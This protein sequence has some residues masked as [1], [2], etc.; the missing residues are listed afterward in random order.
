[1]KS[2]YSLL[3]MLALTSVAMAGTKIATLNVTPGAITYPDQLVGSTSAVATVN[4]KNTSTAKIAFSS[5]EAYGDFH[6]LENGCDKLNPNGKCSVAVT[7]TP[8]LAGSRTGTLVLI[9]NAVS[10]PQ[11][12]ALFGRG[13][14]PN[15]PSPP[16]P[17]PVNASPIVT[18]GANQS[19]TLPATATLSAT[20][21]DDGLPVTSRLSEGW[22]VV[23][24]PGTVSFSNS[25]STATSASFSSPGVYTLRLTA[26]DGDLSAS[27]DLTV[28]VA[29]AVVVPPPPPPPSS[30]NIS[31]IW[32]NEGGDKV[33]QDELRATNH[34]E[35][36][37]GT[38][39]NSVW[40]GSAITLTAARNEVV[41]FN[42]VLEAATAAANSVSIQLDSLTGEAGFSIASKPV[43]GDG[44]FDWTQRNIELFYARYVE[45]KGL[46]FFG[47]F[48]G[49]ERQIPVRFQSASHSWSDRPDHNKFYP[50]ALVPIELVPSFSIAAGHNQS[51]F[52]DV[53]VPKS[54]PPG[55]YTGNVVVF[56]NGAVTKTIPV[57]LTVS[58]FALPDVPAA[59]AFVHLDPMDLIWRFIRPDHSYVQWDGPDGKRAVNVTNKY[60]EL[61]HRHKLGLIAENDGPTMDRPQDTSLPRLNGSLFTAANG[62]DGPGVGT[63]NDIF[64]IGTYGTWG[65][66]AYG[67]APWKKDQNLYWQ[68]TD[69]WEAWFAQNLPGIERFIYLADEPSLSCS[70]ENC[71]SIGEV[72]RWANWTNVNPGPGKDLLTMSTF[73]A[74]PART[75]AADLD[76]PTTAGG[77]GGCPAGVSTCDNKAMTQDAANYYLST[78]GKRFWWYNDGRPGSGTFDTED[79]GISPRTIPWA[80]MKLGVQRWFY[81]FA[82]VSCCSNFFGQALTWGT[83]NHFDAN[84][85]LTGDDGTS[86]GNGFLVYPGSDLGNPQ[87]SY[88]VNGPI[89]SLRLK[90]W[91]R[92][93]Q[94]ADYIAIARQIDP[95]ATA[96][97][98]QAAIP[99]AL[100]ENPAPGGDPSYFIG[101]I[102][103]S[104][105]PDDWEAKR[106]QLSN[107][108]SKG[109]QSNPA[110]AY[111]Q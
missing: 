11:V 86:N 4:V 83:Y 99:K 33:S 81:W 21:T 25:A 44:V 2:F 8:S 94:D 32:A 28:T 6:V 89:A 78:A 50:D 42:L 1:M 76:I 55:L 56:E 26:T 85:G 14:V 62:Y 36:R 67:I 97:I 49:D 90:S 17:P 107:I 66:G 106:S 52:A 71:T 5:V 74:V 102:S 46:S 93:I 61:F 27:A 109:C 45:I 87:D 60:F 37:T 3:S 9:D 70:G 79:D 39:L 98:V 73:S 7:F 10:S 22:S 18:P 31:A 101:P 69:N 12:V 64:S 72:E 23:S 20:V 48:K 68:H 40:N 54:A 58:G 77:I 51:I 41:S 38:V 19:I 84:I 43:T 88:G 82:N 24:G 105:N 35:N 13:I 65:A 91:R 103:W 100:W 53:Y 110:A 104:S 57:R 34:T 111:C 75:L 30:G 96:E 63:A 95:V 15:L 59:K 108:I 92:G 47:Y 16:P 80:Q 29:P